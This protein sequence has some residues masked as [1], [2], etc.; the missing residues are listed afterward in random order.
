VGNNQS[1]DNLSSN[2]PSNTAQKI[3]ENQSKPNNRHPT[4][5]FVWKQPDQYKN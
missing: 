3:T 2:K 1:F 5:K 4:R